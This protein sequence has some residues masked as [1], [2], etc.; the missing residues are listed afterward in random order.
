MLKLIVQAAQGGIAMLNLTYGFEVHTSAVLMTGKVVSIPDM[1]HFWPQGDNT[2]PKLEDE[3]YM[4]H[5]Y[6]LSIT[7]WFD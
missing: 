1:R 4:A 6:V 2:D 3:E 7:L 5:L